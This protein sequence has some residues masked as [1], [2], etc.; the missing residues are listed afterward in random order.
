MEDLADSGP[1][2]ILR[3]GRIFHPNPGSI[4]GKVVQWTFKETGPGLILDGINR[5]DW[6]ERLGKLQCAG[7]ADQSE[8]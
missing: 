5:I 2:Q 6:Q 3:N 7:I 4:K 1:S 8:S